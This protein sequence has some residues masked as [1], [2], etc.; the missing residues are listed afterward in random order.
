MDLSVV[1]VF[2][3]FELLSTTLDLFNLHFDQPE[4]SYLVT[5]KLKIN[6][7][8]YIYVGCSFFSWLLLMNTHIL[9]QMLLAEMV[10]C[11]VYL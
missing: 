6:I 3:D 1:F 8:T 5:Q 10:M 4:T 11:C 7:Y 2:R 9:H